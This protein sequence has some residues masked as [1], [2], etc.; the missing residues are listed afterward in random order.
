MSLDDPTLR[1]PA[2]PADERHARIVAEEDEWRRQR[3]QERATAQTARSIGMMAMINIGWQA[4]S[5]TVGEPDEF[6]MD[7]NGNPVG[8][9][10]LEIGAKTRIVD[11]EMGEFERQ[12]SFTTIDPTSLNYHALTEKQVDPDTVMPPDAALTHRVILRLAREL[13]ASGVTSKSLLMH[14]EERL[15]IVATMQQLAAGLRRRMSA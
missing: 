1:A 15:A 8:G 12:R 6:V 4:W 9:I 7:D 3:D 10:V 14:G 11:E 2:W 5:K 13:V